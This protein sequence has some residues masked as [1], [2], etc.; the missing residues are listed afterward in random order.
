VP[1]EAMNE[2]LRT[3]VMVIALAVLYV[4]LIP[5]IVVELLTKKRLTE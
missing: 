1:E 5:Q 3:V 2:P 4:M